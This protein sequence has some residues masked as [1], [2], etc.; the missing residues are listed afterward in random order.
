MTESDLTSLEEKAKR[1]T[2]GPWHLGHV[3]EANESCEI[4]STS[5]GCGVC[6]AY[7][8]SDQTFIAA[9]NPQTILSL[10]AHVRSLDVEYRK[11][12]EE[13]TDLRVLAA[14]HLRGLFSMAS[15]FDEL[16]RAKFLAKKWNL[17]QW[18][19]T[20]LPEES[21]YRKTREENSALRARVGELEAAN[22]FL[23]EAYTPLEKNSVS[24]EVGPQT[25]ALS[26][27]LANGEKKG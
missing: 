20:K 16:D 15:D 25:K 7:E 18:D 19:E 2:P 3:N 12:L 17:Y 14:D 9:A 13:L 1:A 22:Q 27:L 6:V 11:A 5:D 24:I 26:T 8:R 21:L 4:D 10:I 23:K